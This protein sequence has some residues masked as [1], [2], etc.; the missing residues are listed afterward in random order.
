MSTCWQ[1]PWPRWQ[2]NEYSVLYFVLALIMAVAQYFRSQLAEP[3]AMTT[4]AFFHELFV[5]TPSQALTRLFF[6]R[7]IS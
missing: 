2:W 4:E 3:R 1:L 7:P 5:K 6:R